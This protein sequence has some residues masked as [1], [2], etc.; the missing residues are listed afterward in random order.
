MITL[1]VIAEDNFQAAIVLWIASGTASCVDPVVYSLAE[2][3][4]YN[5]EIKLYL[6]Y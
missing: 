1:Q 5:E 4:L 3:W 2:A 6:I